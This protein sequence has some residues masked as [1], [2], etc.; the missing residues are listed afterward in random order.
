MKTIVDKNTGKVLY[1]TLVEIEL[2]ENEIFI[3]EV[4]GDFNY[5]DFETRTFYNKIDEE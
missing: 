4:S 5:Y 2:Q 3:N 1:A